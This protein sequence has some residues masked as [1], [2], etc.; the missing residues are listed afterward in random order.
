M[1]SNCFSMFKLIL[2]IVIFD[3]KNHLKHLLRYLYHK[4]LLGPWDKQIRVKGI[5][6]KYLVTHT[7]DMFIIDT[8]E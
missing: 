5:L 2:Y 8:P 7:C 4:I 6:Y 1:C 3:S